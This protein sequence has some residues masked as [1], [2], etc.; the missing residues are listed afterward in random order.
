[1]HYSK[2]GS[3]GVCGFNHP[4]FVHC[5]D[6]DQWTRATPAKRCAE[7]NA[8]VGYGDKRERVRLRKRA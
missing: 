2:D 7:C 8:L 3:T 4:G 5:T 6:L 1:M